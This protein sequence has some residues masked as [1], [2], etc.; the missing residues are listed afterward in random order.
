MAA[1]INDRKADWSGLVLL[2]GGAVGTAPSPR[3]KEG[4]Q[5]AVAI[6]TSS[7]L[8]GRPGESRDPSPPIVVMKNDSRLRRLLIGRGVWVPAFAGTT[9]Q[10]V[11]VHGI[12]PTHRRSLFHGSHGPLLG[13]TGK[14][15]PRHR[16]AAGPPR[17]RHG[18]VQLS[19]QSFPQPC[20][21]QYLDGGAG[22]RRLSPHFVLAIPPGCDRVLHRHTGP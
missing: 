10:K 11:L 17:L 8:G 18:A 21:R 12:K 1:A 16:P 3:L 4:C 13:Q 14:I 20:A 5:R 9:C 6:K 2:S 7:I 15:D 22:D 19:G